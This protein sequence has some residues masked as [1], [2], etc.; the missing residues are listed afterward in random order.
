MGYWSS[1]SL[2]Y[3][4]LSLVFRS[5]S[6]QQSNNYCVHPQTVITWTVNQL[7]LY[8]CLRYSIF[9]ILSYGI[10]PCFPHEKKTRWQ[11][12]QRHPAPR[13][14]LDIIVVDDAYPR[15]SQDILLITGSVLLLGEQVTLMQVVGE[16][17][18]ILCSLLSSA[19]FF[20]GW[21][22]NPYLYPISIVYFISAFFIF[23]VF[24]E[25]LLYSHGH[26]WSAKAMVML[27][28]R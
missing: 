19:P 27:P 6:K 17:Y 5:S 1:L 8:F 12:P 28:A 26:P 15:C 13:L 23:A 24:L 20:S 14:H 3:S 16:L 10:T 21:K 4:C 18:W 11:Q 22:A 2:F 25:L 9:C 7:G